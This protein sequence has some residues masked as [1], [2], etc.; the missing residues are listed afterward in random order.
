MICNA[1][2]LGVAVLRQ[3]T[4][5]ALAGMWGFARPHSVG[6]QTP[7]ASSPARHPNFAPVEPA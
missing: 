7:R 3:E 2:L 5:A 4:G 6:H 1:D